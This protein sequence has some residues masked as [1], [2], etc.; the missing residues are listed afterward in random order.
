MASNSWDSLYV[1]TVVIT[2]ASKA[3]IYD[4]VSEA[5]KEKTYESI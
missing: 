4:D 1:C 5:G 3:K 2:E